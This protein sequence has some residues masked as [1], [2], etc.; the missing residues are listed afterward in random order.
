MGGS[1][2]M[3]SCGVFCA[4]AAVLLFFICYRMGG[5]GG[6]PALWI[7]IPAAEHGWDV[8]SKSRACRNAGI[9]YS[10]LAGLLFAGTPVYDALRR[11][12]L[13]RSL[14]RCC[15]TS[16]MHARRGLCPGMRIPVRKGSDL[17]DD[18]QASDEYD[19]R[20]WRHPL[21]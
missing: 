4:L 10:I 8:Q 14:A 17:S 6:E 13:G 19:G 11:T 21:Q 9:I 12:P 7:R 18:T 1:G 2:L 3:L 20:R 5:F 15:A 16:R